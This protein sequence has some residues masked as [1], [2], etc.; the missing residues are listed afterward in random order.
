MSHE[1]LPKILVTWPKNTEVF[2]LAQQQDVA[3]HARKWPAG[4]VMLHDDVQRPEFCFIGNPHYT[5]ASVK[6]YG[7]AQRV[8][9]VMA[10]LAYAAI[11]TLAV[12]ALIL[13]MAGG[14]L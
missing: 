5:E 10:G 2:T 4:F 6:A 12:I 8:R 11:V 1:L 7:K 13:I 9:G 14:R 3:G